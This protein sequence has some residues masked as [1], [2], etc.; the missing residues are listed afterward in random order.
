MEKER[1]LIG[2]RKPRSETIEYAVMRNGVGERLMP[3]LHERYHAE[4]R[5]M[6]ADMIPHQRLMNASDGVEFHDAARG[7]GVQRWVIHQMERWHDGL[8]K[9][10]HSVSL[11]TRWW[12]VARD[13]GNEN[14]KVLGLRLGEIGPDGVRNNCIMGAAVE[15]FL[16]DYPAALV[17]VEAPNAEEREQLGLSYRDVL[18]SYYVFQD[19]SE[20]TPVALLPTIVQRHLGIRDTVG[21]FDPTEKVDG[22]LLRHYNAATAREIDVAANASLVGL[23]DRTGNWPLLADVMAEP[24]A[25]VFV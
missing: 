17:V 20:P 18:R 3:S 19:G 15:L 23:N 13:G 7:A 11:S 6:F 9:P 21:T 14:M 24:S 16:E 1:M 2:V 8:V 12:Q 25:R 5:R 10:A 22:V 4:P